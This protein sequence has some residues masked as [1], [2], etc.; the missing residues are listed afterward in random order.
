MLDVTVLK[1]AHQDGNRL[2][3]QWQ[4]PA[5]SCFPLSATLS[6]VNNGVVSTQITRTAIALEVGAPD[7]KYFR[8]NF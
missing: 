6:R 2:I 8:K 4:A 3:E 1:V 7:S 5:L